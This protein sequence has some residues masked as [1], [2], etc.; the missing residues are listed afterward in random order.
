MYLPSVRILEC[1]QEVTRK[2]VI[3]SYQSIE[4]VTS[5]YMSGIELQYCLAN[6]LDLSLS[7][8]VSLFFTPFSPHVPLGIGSN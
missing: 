1:V 3:I 5:C 4:R 7:L 6:F 2:G 8:S